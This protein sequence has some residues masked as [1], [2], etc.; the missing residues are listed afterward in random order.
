MAYKNIL[1]SNLGTIQ[2]NTDSA[3]PSTLLSDIATFSINP[4]TEPTIEIDCDSRMINIPDEIRSI[5][6]VAGDH[7]A[8][9]FY[10]HIPRYFDDKDLSEHRAIIRYINAGKE[11]GESEAVNLKIEEND[12]TLGWQ[13]DNKATRYAGEISFTIQFETVEDGIKYQW[14][15]LPASLTV[16]SG[17]DIETTIT[18][19]DDLLFRTL[20]KQIQD[21]QNKFD[22][23]INSDLIKNSD[24]YFNKINTLEESIKYLEE[25]VVYVSKE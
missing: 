19:K 12:L 23:L 14:Q 17:L 10:F 21:L 18:D 3:Q 24:I 11:Y 2:K 15:T 13:I 1:L 22:S 5:G 6:I 7:M 4:S 25:N 9:T 20:N 16:K 8:E